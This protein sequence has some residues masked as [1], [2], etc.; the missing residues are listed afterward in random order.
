[1]PPL[2]LHAAFTKL[3]VHRSNQGLPGALP[4]IFHRAGQHA[5]CFPPHVS[6]YFDPMQSD[7]RAEN[8]EHG[9]LAKQYGKV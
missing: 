5:K 3:E 6:C 8:I 7:S 4:E 2:R 9:L 1:M